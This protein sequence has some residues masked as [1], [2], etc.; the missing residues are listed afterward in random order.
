MQSNRRY[1]IYALA[2]GMC[3]CTTG[4]AANHGEKEPEESALTEL[5][6]LVTTAQTEA[7]Q[8]TAETTLTAEAELPEPAFEADVT[9]WKLPDELGTLQ[10]VRVHNGEI[11]LLG[12]QQSETQQQKS[13]LFRA[14]AEEEPV[15]TPLFD[16]ADE[17]NFVGLTDFD[18]LSDGTICG[19]VCENSNA[20]PYEDPT[21]D[22]E[23]F[24]WESYYENYTTQYRLVWYNAD[25]EITRK[26]GLSTLLDLNESARQTMAFTGIRSD[27]S[28]HV[29]LTATID[30]QECL[31][32]LDDRGNLLPIQ[33][34]DSN[35]LSLE[36]DYQWIRC[37][38]DGMLLLE[39]DTEETL[40]LSHLVITD[41]T[42]W[43][44]EI[45]SS[46]LLAVSSALAEE[47]EEHIWYGFWDENGVYRVAEKNAK[48]ELLYTWD[49][50]GLDAAEVERV[51]V[52]PE[53]K[54]LLTT[55]TSQGNLTI[56]LVTPEVEE[57]ETD[58][59][60]TKETTTVPANSETKSSSTSP[61]VATP[62]NFSCIP[63]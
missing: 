19:L 29:Y 21:F 24:D 18:V 57:T 5:P 49:D 3:I 26:M 27:A 12:V 15:F 50:L 34:N 31:M 46:E 43:K 33:G 44:T 55:Y 40:Q 11:Y 25:G 22:P 16:T 42:L 37:G 39:K 36:S 28:D 60:V 13:I 58:T 7:S 8:T 56:Q 17:I 32:T 20:V 23:Q 4:C 35:I 38:S 2:L 47:A 14:S 61:P 51:L 6:P 54:A 63:E 1:R 9:A 48:P 41:N 30:E 52:L 10:A 45:T 59:V 62:V 53:T